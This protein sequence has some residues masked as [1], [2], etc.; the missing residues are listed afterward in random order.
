MWYTCLVGGEGGS[1]DHYVPSNPQIP[2]YDIK[3]DLPTERKVQGLHRN[4]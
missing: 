3:R 4:L 1:L 2:K